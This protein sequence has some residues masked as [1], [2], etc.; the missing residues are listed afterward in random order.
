MYMQIRITSQ[1]GL[2]KPLVVEVFGLTVSLPGLAAGTALTV[3]E[4]PGGLEARIEGAGAAA[5]ALPLSQ[6]EAPPED[7]REE[8]GG[9]QPEQLF[10]KLSALRKKVAAESGVPPYVVFHDNTLR[11]MERLLPTDLEALGAVQ[12]VGKAKLEK[13]GELFIAAIAAHKGAAA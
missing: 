4:G 3:S 1:G 8:G 10:D 11:E 5:V 6:E 9:Q 13:Y 12:G 7:M 2:E